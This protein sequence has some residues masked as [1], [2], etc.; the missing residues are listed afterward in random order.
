MG[1]VEFYTYL[2]L[3]SGAAPSLAGNK[4]STLIERINPQENPIQKR[5]QPI[6]DIHLYS[7]LEREFGQ[8]GSVKNLYIM[9]ALGLLIL[10]IA[11]IN[12]MNLATARSAN[13]ALEVGLRKVIGAQRPQLIQ[14]FMLEAIL[15]AAF[16]L[17]ITLVLVTV[18]LPWF[19]KMM[20]KSLTMGVDD[21]LWHGPAIGIIVVLVGFVS[22]IYPSLFLSAFQPLQAIRQQAMIRSRGLFRHLLVMVQFAMAIGLIIGTLI[23][24]QQLEFTRNK[25]LGF[26]KEQVVIVEL[27]GGLWGQSFDAWKKD[28]L[29]HSRVIGISK[30]API[31]GKPLDYM[32]LQRIDQPDRPAVLVSF[33]GVYDDYIKTMGLDVIASQPLP[34]NWKSDPQ[35]SPVFLNETAVRRFGWLSPDEAIGKQL[36]RVPP[37]DPDSRGAR[38]IVFNVVKDFHL[39]SLHHPVDPMVIQ[40]WTSQLGGYPIIRIASE[41]APET[42]AYLTQVWK[43]HFPD[44]PFS[45]TSMDTAFGQLYREEE[46]LSQFSFILAILAIVIACMGVFG[47]ASFTVEQRTREI[48]IRKVLGESVTGIIHL[49]TTEFV[50]LVLV[51]SVIAYPITYLVMEQWLQSFAYRIGITGWPFLIA[52]IATI[53]IVLLTVSYQAI[54]AA[55]ANPVDSLR[56]E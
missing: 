54:R 47:L 31:P 10:L 53:L 1:L 56:Y 34:L 9:T 19:N 45:Y 26:P 43:S 8:S 49:L 42:L 15:P 5:L 36:D 28:A 29:G 33:D 7:Q 18:A 51:A 11:C 44:V 40:M 39:L 6:T 30:P 3:E 41:D 32:T 22:G 21:L 24:Y 12:F 46:R 14:Q 27:F 25:P 17:P 50:K 52:G 13:R 23:V 55:Y 2:L 20:N 35:L 4:I 16:A 38:M 37:T 48:G